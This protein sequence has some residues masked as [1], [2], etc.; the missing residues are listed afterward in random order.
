MR[1][2]GHIAL[3][4]ALTLSP[5]GNLAWAEVVDVTR[6]VGASGSLA[7][8]VSLTVQ[9]RT[10]AADALAA[11]IAFGTVTGVSIA[12]PWKVAPQYLKVQHASNHNNW[13]IRIYTNNK[14]TKPTTVGTVLGD[15]GTTCDP[16]L[17]ASSA[18]TDD[19]RGYGGLIGTT[20]TNPNDR[21]PWAWQVYKD[22]VVGGP[23]TPVDD[24]GDGAL[25][26]GVNEVGGFFNAPWA[27]IAD[28]SDCPSTPAVPLN[29]TAAPAPTIDKTIEFLQVAV[30]DAAN[31]FLKLHPLTPPR[32]SDGDVAVYIA[33]RF[34]GAPADTFTATLILELYHQ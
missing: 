34:G 7:T 23:A 18:C 6:T 25:D 24:D 9:P 16:L 20:P 17:P 31:A 2:L 10:I 4:W 21:V 14:A 13:A 11:S 26:V 12:A 3:T 19:P 27:F 33:G 28:A 15:N 29:C 32:D 5:V 1:G 22:V 30:G 8:T